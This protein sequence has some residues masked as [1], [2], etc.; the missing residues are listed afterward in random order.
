MSNEKPIKRIHF[1]CTEVSSMS[2]HKRNFL[3][4]MSLFTVI[5]IKLLRNIIIYYLVFYILHY[6]LKEIFLVLIQ[7]NLNKI[8]KVISQIYNF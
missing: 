3:Q 6:S 8:T 4:N 2:S 7:S 1:S 5:T